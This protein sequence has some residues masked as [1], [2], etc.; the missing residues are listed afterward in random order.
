MDVDRLELIEAAAMQLTH[1]ERTILA[2][3]LLESL[4]KP[5]DIMAAWVETAERRAD[6]HERG[7]VQ[8]VTL[9]AAMRHA[10][11]GLPEHR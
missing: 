11:A 9:N 6:A 2:E 10:F 4:D 5:D 1:A 3:H 7:E 8:V